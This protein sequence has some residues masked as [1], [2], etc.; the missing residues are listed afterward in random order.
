MEQ[1]QNN[2]TIVEQLVQSFQHANQ[3]IGENAVGVQE[4]NMQFAQ[5]LYSDWLATL[6]DHAGNYQA[7]LQEMKQQDAFQ[8]LVQQSVI[9]YFDAMIA[10]LASFSPALRLSEKLQICLLAFA[11]RYPRHRVTINEELLGPQ[12]LG[13]EGWKATD[14]IELL[15]HTT[16][17]LLQAPARLEVTAQRK[18]IYLLDRSEEIPAFRVYCGEMGEKTPPHRGDMSTRQAEQASRRDEALGGPLPAGELQTVV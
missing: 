4:R 9:S 16:P 7:L 8:K 5:R 1:K 15:Q 2:E 12:T 10:E 3:A 18:G 11:S 13:A 17:E 6:E 14:L